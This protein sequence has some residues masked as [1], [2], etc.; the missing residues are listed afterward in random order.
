MSDQK[1]ERETTSTSKSASTLQR[2]DLLRGAAAL[3]AGGVA[4]AARRRGSASG[5]RGAR[6]RREVLSRFSHRE[7]S[8]DG[9]VIH[10][11]IG[12]SGPPVLLLHGAPQ[13]RVSWPAVARELARDYT[14]VVADLRGYG[15]SGKMQG[16][17]DHN[18][19]LETHDGARSSRGHAP[20]RLRA[21]QRVRPRSRRARHAPHGARSS[22]SE[23]SGR[24]CST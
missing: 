7:G 1:N 12:G 2:R 14:V 21:L 24:R 16:S 11:V 9:A 10:A 23:S 19:V 3:V 15:D 17:D 8:D 20:F 5:A 13:S 4:L 6:R 22:A 18:R